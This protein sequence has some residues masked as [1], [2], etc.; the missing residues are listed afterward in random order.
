VEAAAAL[1]EPSAAVGDEAVVQIEGE[2]EKEP[3]EVSM[4]PAPPGLVQ[5]GLKVGL[6]FYCCLATVLVH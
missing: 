4:D 1:P 3:E 2:E 6:L 5:E